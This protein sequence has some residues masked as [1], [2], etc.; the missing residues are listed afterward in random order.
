MGSFS[1]CQDIFRKYNILFVIVELCKMKYNENIN[2]MKWS[3][4][5]NH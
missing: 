1:F 4:Y 3:A 2:L 5:E